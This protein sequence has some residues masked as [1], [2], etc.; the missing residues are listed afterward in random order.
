[1]TQI[2]TTIL[3]TIMTKVMTKVMTKIV[4]K[5]SQKSIVSSEASDAVSLCHI[6]RF[7]IATLETTF[8]ARYKVE[9]LLIKL[10]NPWPCGRWAQIKSEAFGQKR[11][12]SSIS[13]T[14]FRW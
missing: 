4:T 7:K 11:A 2:M 5:I 6:F 8:S 9:S 3:T 13:E 10:K 1:M 12:P 14:Y